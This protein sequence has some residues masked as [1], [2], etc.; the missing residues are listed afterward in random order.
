VV[1]GSFAATEY[2]QIAAPTQ[3]VLYVPDSADFARRHELMPA[4]QGANVVLLN[5]AGDSQLT[6]F[7]Q[8]GDGTR[9]A[10][11]SQ[12]AL[13]CLGGNGRL[14]EEGDALIEWMAANL[15]AWRR[16]RLSTM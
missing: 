15:D 11:I 5:A 4:Q 10:G 1:T 3:L 2:V 9:H 13:D 7:R 6:R 8:C 14:P 12:V 16:P